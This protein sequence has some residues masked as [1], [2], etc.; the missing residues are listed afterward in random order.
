VKLGDG[1]EKRC[2]AAFLPSISFCM[3]AVGGDDWLLIFVV[4]SC[5]VHASTAASCCVVPLVPRLVPVDQG[6]SFDAETQEK[7]ILRQAALRRPHQTRLKSA[8]F[9]VQSWLLSELEFFALWNARLLPSNAGRCSKRLPRMRTTSLR[10]Y[11]G[12]RYASGS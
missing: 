11:R 7:K 5:I 12:K 3:L 6:L 2:L 8:G 1:R 9:V 4:H 10:L